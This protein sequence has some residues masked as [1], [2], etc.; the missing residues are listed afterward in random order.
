M[1]K[2][3]I[4]LIFISFLSIYCNIL[5][6]QCYYH[7]CTDG[8][9]FGYQKLQF[10]NYPKDI[11]VG[12]G[13]GLIF[14]VKINFRSCFNAYSGR[15][16]V[17]TNPGAYVGDHILDT[18]NCTLTPGATT[19]IPGILYPDAYLATE[20]MPV[21]DSSIYSFEVILI[22][23][24]NCSSEYFLDPATPYLTIHKNWPTGIN[25]K[26]KNE[27]NIYPTITSDQVH[28]NPELIKNS[29]GYL[30]N[31]SGI[32]VSKITNENISLAGFLNGLYCFVFIN[33][34]D[35]TIK[36]YQVVKF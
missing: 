8:T 32:L 22:D 21:G 29:S 34:K 16:V 31:S 5:M 3:R 27:I 35:K 13:P 11:T 12:A 6:A 14:D 25:E 7:G 33:E 23:N 10:I 9:G 19:I 28:I 15:A 1:K 26:Q 36:K 17:R 4:V 30:F 20:G 18:V 24:P 2:L